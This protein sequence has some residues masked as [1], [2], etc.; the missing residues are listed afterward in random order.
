MQLP[1]VA[2]GAFVVGGQRSKLGRSSQKECRMTH[3]T[4]LKNEMLA[5][6]ENIIN[7]LLTAAEQ[8]EAMQLSDI[9]R[10]V[11]AAGEEMMTSLTTQ[12]VA[13]EAQ[14]PVSAICPKCGQKMHNKGKKRRNLATETGEIQVERAY[15][16]CPTCR[17]GH[18]PPGPPLADE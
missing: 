18:F 14:Q 8:K 7:E 3:K 12:L 11:R 9:E 10:L 13:A 16:Y 6:A 2:M 15:Y 1:W 17:E 5:A 4:N